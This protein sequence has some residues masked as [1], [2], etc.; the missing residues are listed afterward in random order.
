MVNESEG[1]R[2]DAMAGEAS[3]VTTA[4]REEARD[5]AQ[6][7][8]VQAQDTIE[9]ARQEAQQLGDAA[10]THAQDVFADVRHELRQ[11]ANEQGTRAAQTLHDT[12]D[13]LRQMAHSGEGGVLVDLAQSAA[14]R[15]DDVAR[16]VERQGVD[17]LLED[18]RSYARR[19]PGTFLVAAGVAGFV[20][21]R[22]VRN[23]SSAM[24][25]PQQQAPLPSPSPSPAPPPSA[26]VTSLSPT[27][28]SSAESDYVGGATP[29]IT[30]P[31]S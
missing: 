21:G 15:I 12:S 4:S 30:G 19:R 1:G 7:A 9:T 27:L 13:Q 6:T 28:A 29:S 31:Q 8:K 17:G 11:R 3:A 24:A 22:L 23:A 20:V 14:T 10:K 16:R 26:P 5:V 25:G 18:V 2:T